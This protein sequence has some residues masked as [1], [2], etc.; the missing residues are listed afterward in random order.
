MKKLLVTLASLFLLTPVVLAV[1]GDISI[2]S[3]DISFSN[4]NFLEGRTVR[5][6]ATAKNNSTKDLLGI[7]RFY[8]NN[9]QISA[10]QAISIFA[11]NSDGVFVDWTPG[12]GSHR[13]AVKIFPWEDSIDN[14]DNNWI[15]TEIFALQDTDHD[16]TQ[17]DQDND[18]DNDNVSDTEDA[19]PL[20][21]SEQHDI[22]G[23]SIGD[24][25]D[26]DADNDGV[27]DNV[28]DLPLDPDETTDNDQDEIG[29]ISDPDDDNDGLTDK[30]EDNSGLNSLNSDTDADSVNDKEDAF[31]LNPNESLDTDK[32]SLGNTIDIDDDNDS[33]P[34]HKDDFPLNKGPIIKLD[35][36]STTIDL[37]KDHIFDAS[38]SYDE[39]GEI[40][41]YLWEIDGEE[42]EGNS[43]PYAFDKL[44]KHNVKLTVTDNSGESRSEE[45][46]INILNLGLYQQI[47][48]AVIAT[49]L[50][51]LIYFKYI[52]DTKKS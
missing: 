36:Q 50:A 8:D 19:F 2:N 25:Q 41:S 48:L 23:D 42:V 46:Q 26:E 14:P 37:L 6:Y 5:I 16:G 7:V 1:S 30:E 28:D 3:E 39:D 15:V 17:N 13:I 24:N 51:L 35:D 20:D 34:D 44:G 40:V 32:D 21:S 33:I 18:D 29:N 31:P 11:G 45:F 52:A 27:P 4:N 22:D 49:S 47:I 9:V 38:P 10:D 12:Y 43:V